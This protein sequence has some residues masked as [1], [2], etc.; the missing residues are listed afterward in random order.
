MEERGLPPPGQGGVVRWCGGAGVP[1]AVCDSLAGAGRCG[2][3]RLVAALS[4][5]A[6]PAADHNI[7]FINW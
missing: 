6:W 2:H 7:T 5:L 1:P 4:G 3:S